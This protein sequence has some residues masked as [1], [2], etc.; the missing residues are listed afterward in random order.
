MRIDCLHGRGKA[1]FY[2]TLAMVIVGSSVVFGKIIIVHFP[3]FLVSELRFLIASLL[4]A[5][6]FFYRKNRD[7]V[8]DKKDWFIL[9]CMAFCGQV[10]FTVGMLVGL[11]Y[12]SAVTAGALTSTTPVFMTLIAFFV[13]KERLGTWQILGVCIAS[14]GILLLNSE[15]LLNHD[16]ASA[17]S[18]FVGNLWI[19]LAVVGEAFFLLLAKKLTVTLSE[20]YITG[21]LSVLGALMFLPLAVYEAADFS[22]NSVSYL[23]WFCVFYFGAVYTVLA[24]IFW[25]RGLKIVSGAMAG[26]FTAVMPL[27]AALLSV[28]LLHETCSYLQIMAIFLIVLAILIL[29]RTKEKN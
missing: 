18:E 23:D 27:S 3:V 26:S 5:P 10:V 17:A 28:L 24:Y 7:K 25:F 9:I 13:L 11:R 16:K 19:C 8:I 4:I 15:A 21:I 2:L 12:T 1:F 14:I 22:W 29:A 6:V 20:T